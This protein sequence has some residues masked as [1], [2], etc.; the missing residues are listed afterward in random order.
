MNELCNLDIWTSASG[1][2]SYEFGYL[3]RLFLNFNG[4]TTHGLKNGG[5]SSGGRIFD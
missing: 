5:D 4:N 1:I 2:T 3:K